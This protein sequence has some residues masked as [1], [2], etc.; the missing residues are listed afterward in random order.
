MASGQTDTDELQRECEQ[1]R[2]RVRQLEAERAADKQ[3]L[4]AVRAEADEY[5]HWLQ[6]ELQKQYTEEEVQRFGQLEDLADCQTLEQFLPALE[7]TIRAHS[8]A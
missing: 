7:Q 8:R 2:E 3:A 6:L 1:L 4:A 5:R